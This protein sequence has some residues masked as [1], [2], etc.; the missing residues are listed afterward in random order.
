MAFFVGEEEKTCFDDE[1]TSVGGSALPPKDL[2]RAQ[3]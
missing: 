2:L 1:G 3:C